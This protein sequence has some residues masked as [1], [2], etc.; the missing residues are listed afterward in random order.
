MVNHFGE[1]IFF[2]GTHRELGPISIFLMVNI[3][4]FGH[5]G[6]PLLETLGAVFA[7]LFLGALALKHRTFLLG[8]VC[9]WIVAMSMDVSALYR[10]GVEW[11]F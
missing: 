3:Y 6:K 7:G 8:A 10:R 2:L 1:D 5:F 9:H 4:V 11:T